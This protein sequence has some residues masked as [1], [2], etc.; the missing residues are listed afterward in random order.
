MKKRSI[1]A[2]SLS[3]TVAVA[4]AF[5]ETTAHY[6]T[7]SVTAQPA[8]FDVVSQQVAPVTT[9]ADLSFAFDD[10]ENLQAL[11][12][13]DGEMAETQGAALPPVLVGYGIRAGVM[14]T[15]GAGTN[16]WNH[17]STTGR[18]SWKAAGRGFVGGAMAGVGAK[19]LTK[20]GW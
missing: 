6:N 7:P 12:M 1:L 10:A 18:W 2:L 3:A 20:R 9:Q 8:T 15:I 13:T 19:Y 17:Y 5:A 14:G 16:A 4:P 11:A